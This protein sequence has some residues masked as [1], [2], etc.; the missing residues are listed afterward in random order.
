ML[1]IDHLIVVVHD[2][3][4]TASQYDQDKGLASVAGGL[5]PGHGTVNR[6][7]PLGGSY[8][9]LMAVVDRDQA[10]AS[11]LGSWVLRRLVE[12]GEGPAALCL[13]T[14]DLDAAAR[15][16]MRTPLRMSRQRPDGVELN[17]E[18]VALDAA[19]TEGRPFFIR[20]HVDDSEHPGRAPV[21]HRCRAVGIDWVE[22][23]GDP[24]RIDAWLGPHE[25]PIRH[26]GGEPGPHRFGVARAG[27]DPIVID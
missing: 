16:T 17:W 15:R 1:A 8:I 9:E 3:E 20:W 27:G 2:L 10:A 24:H 26:L 7:V 21:T 13:R 14:D 12:Q 22:L 25:L 18:L 23:G 4:T 6:I 5:H 11:P 19:I